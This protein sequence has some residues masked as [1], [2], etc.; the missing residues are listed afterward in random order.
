MLYVRA[1]VSMETLC[2]N[3]GAGAKGTPR[4]ECVCR[5]TNTTILSQYWCSLVLV[6]VCI[7]GVN[8]VWHIKK[9]RL[10][11]IAEWIANYFYT[12]SWPYFNVPPEFP[13][14]TFRRRIHSKKIIKNTKLMTS[15]D[16]DSSHEILI[17]FNRLK[18]K[19]RKPENVTD[20]EGDNF[21]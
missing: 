13:F 9:S 8:G 1:R 10:M 17:R 4:C 21:F 19:L 6:F 2:I 20:I 18:L 16:F 11:K 14:H 12:L 7:G 5:N 3:R 15:T